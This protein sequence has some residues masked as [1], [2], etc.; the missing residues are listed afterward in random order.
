[1]RFWNTHCS[2]AAAAPARPEALRQ[3]FE[4]Y[5]LEKAIQRGKVANRR[6]EAAVTADEAWRKV[7]RS[8]DERQGRNAERAETAQGFRELYR[9]QWDVDELARSLA[10]LCR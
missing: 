3:A 10:W 8:E 9:K 2:R 7:M 4:M 1:M 5:I 6:L